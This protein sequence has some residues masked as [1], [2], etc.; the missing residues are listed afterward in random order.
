MDK[1]K[2]TIGLTPQSGYYNNNYV[3]ADGDNKYIVRV[4]IADCDEMDLRIIPEKYVLEFLSGR[5]L[6]VPQLLEVHSNPDYQVHEYI[7]GIV[8]NDGYPRGTQLP[9]YFI[10]QTVNFIVRLFALDS[11]SL[12]A[13]FPEWPADGDTESYFLRMLEEVEHTYAAFWPEYGHLFQRY[14]LPAQPFERFRTAAASLQSRPFVLA[15]CDIHRKN[16]I[17]R[18]GEVI[19]LDWELALIAD[20]VYEIS[21][22]LHKMDYLPEEEARFLQL[23]E[24]ELP[25]ELAAGF[26]A[27]LQLYRELEQAKSLI[28]DTVRYSK[29]LQSNEIDRREKLEL[30][31]KLEKKLKQASSFWNVELFTA[32]QLFAMLS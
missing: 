19:F 9:E 29:Q 22:H 13:W 11:S 31:D 16:G 5:G 23:M 14:G 3:V 10:P 30:A 18:E 8:V 15:H 27:D 24:R 26:Q 2:Q 4:P 28:V 25:I 32:Q 6:P 17:L 7:D 20:P 1:L 12:R 21:V